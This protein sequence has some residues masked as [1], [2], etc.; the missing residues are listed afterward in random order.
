MSWCSKWD[1]L[2][3]WWQELTYVTSVKETLEPDE[4]KSR[5]NKKRTNVHVWYK[6]EIY[7]YFI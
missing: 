6:M 1:T 7:D 3:I 5:E 2:C 4:T